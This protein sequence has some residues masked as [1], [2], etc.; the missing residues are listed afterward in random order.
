MREV[1]LRNLAYTYL[2]TIYLFVTFL[3][4]LV[5]AFHF[6]IYSLHLMFKINYSFLKYSTMESFSNYAL[7][8]IAND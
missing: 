5:H 7:L 4:Q 3:K 6:M 8:F 1:I 2:T